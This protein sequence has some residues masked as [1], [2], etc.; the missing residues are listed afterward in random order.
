[1]GL[2]DVV[3][4]G[5]FRRSSTFAV[6]ILGG[7]IVF[8]TYFNEICDKWLAQHNAGVSIWPCF[9]KFEF[10]PGKLNH[11]LLK[12][13]VFNLFT[14]IYFINHLF[15]YDLVLRIYIAIYKQVSKF[16]CNPVVSGIWRSIR[17][18]DRSTFW[19]SITQTAGFQKKKKLLTNGCSFNVYVCGIIENIPNIL[20]IL[21]TINFY[22]WNKLNILI[23]GRSDETEFFLL[24]SLLIS[25]Q[26]HTNT[27]V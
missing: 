6:A 16:F 9:R 5:V 1:M 22:L 3:Y 4:R 11:D 23:S 12:L 2:V 26:C 24:M 17:Y 20:Y 18:R 27:S 8:E 7:A 25:Y 19:G 21:C 10:P 15:H 13:Q 14:K